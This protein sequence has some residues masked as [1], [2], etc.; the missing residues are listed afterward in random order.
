MIPTETLVRNGLFIFC[1]MKIK[2][3]INIVV[4]FY[5][6]WGSVGSEL[7]N[8]LDIIHELLTTEKPMEFVENIKDSHHCISFHSKLQSTMT[9]TGLP[10][11]GDLMWL[12]ELPE[13]DDPCGTGGMGL[14]VSDIV[15]PLGISKG[16]P[17]IVNA[18]FTFREGIVAYLDEDHGKT[19]MELI[20]SHFDEGFC[21]LFVRPLKK[22]GF[23][24]ESI[25]FIPHLD[26]E[27]TFQIDYSDLK[28]FIG[29][30][31]L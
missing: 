26:N 25:G 29:S 21:E 11:K 5:C 9:V 22:M 12:P 14:T 8:P 15:H 7:R 28:S 23:A 24:L 18:E 20:K 6:R 4:P 10:C 31:D 19:T 3:V 17:T 16:S 2:L 1:T 30:L 27:F 13:N